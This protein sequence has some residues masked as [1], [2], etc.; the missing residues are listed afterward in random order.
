MISSEL[1]PLDHLP[2]TGIYGI[3]KS[4]VEKYAYSL[5]ME[6]QLLGY[7]VVLIRPGA[8]DTGLINVSVDKLDRFTR[9]TKYY[10]YNSKKF[11]KIVNSVENK[12]IHPS[13]LAN[14]IYKVSFKKK[15]RYV[16]KINRNFLLLVLNAL[17]QHFQNW[18]IKKIL[19]SK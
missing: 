7:Q 3:T 16:Y 15:P 11:L 17:P 8:I 4:T 13:K 12:K 10:Q 14:L 6:L 9:D 2:F 5:R 1:G 19:T 18:V